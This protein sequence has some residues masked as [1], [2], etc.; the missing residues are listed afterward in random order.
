MAPHMSKLLGVATALYGL[1]I[2]Q[3]TIG[4]SVSFQGPFDVEQ[5][6]LHNI[7]VE[8]HEQLNGELTIVY[9][10]CTIDSPSQAHHQIG[11]T[12][13]GN[14]PAAKRHLDWE[15]QRPTKFVWVTPSDVVSGCLHAFVDGGLVGRSEQV[16][17]K[18]RK[19]TRRAT[20]ADVAEPLG[21]WFDGVEYMKQKEPDEVFVAATKKK[22]FGILGGGMS[23]L[24]TSVSRSSFPMIASLNCTIRFIQYYSCCS[25]QWAFTTG[26]S[27]NLLAVWVVASGRHILTTPSRRTTSITN[28]VPCVSHNP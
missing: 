10:S 26:R 13:I 24:M 17:V 18:K 5:G 4:Q 11:R 22:S 23:G 1:C 27:L 7:H 25:T 19:L 3:P 21:A 14:H 6:G 20:L 16:S 12:H 15:E 2:A 28:L 9:G 8:Y